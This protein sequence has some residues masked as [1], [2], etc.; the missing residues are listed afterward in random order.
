MRIRIDLSYDGTD[1]HGWAAQPGL[2]TVEGDLVSALSVVLQREIQLT[3]AGRTDAGVHAFGQTVHADL[4]ES[5]WSRLTSGGRHEP[6]SALA[7]RL[8]SLISRNSRLPRGSS[9][10]V[11]S[12]ITPISDDF[13]ARFS[14]LSRRYRYRLDD[15]DV[16]S[17]FRTRYVWHTEPLNIDAMQ[18]AGAHLLGEH[19]FLTFCKPREGATTIRELRSVQVHRPGIGEDA[20]LVLVD[21]EADAFC[22]SM[23]RSIVHG[24]VQVGKGLKE[25]GWI[26]DKLGEVSRSAGI[27]LAPAHG[28]TLMGVTYPEPEDFGSRARLARR[29][30]E[31]PL[32]ATG[33]LIDPEPPKD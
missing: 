24:L 30:R 1:F 12:R 26:A 3:V 16:P 22:H 19:D 17:V 27:G 15:S 28:L 32:T 13:D 9:D 10:I 11:I 29:V 31:N 23:V 14:A 5:E 8:M 6:G 20:G 18:A 21:L 33:S 7:A 4:S 2:R 25:P